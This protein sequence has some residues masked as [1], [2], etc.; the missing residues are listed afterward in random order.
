MEWDQI[1]EKWSQMALRLRS[2]SPMGRR[3]QGASPING[4]QDR[5]LAQT[6]GPNPSGDGVSGT[7]LVERAGIE[8]GLTPG[9]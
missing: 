8:R 1:A 6:T 5:V 7:R 2:D 9:R 3:M 4:L